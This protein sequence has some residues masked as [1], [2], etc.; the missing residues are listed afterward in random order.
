MGILRAVQH[1]PG[2]GVPAVNV[3]V[4]TSGSV[5][6][7]LADVAGSC[8]ATLEALVRIEEAIP[9]PTTALA[10]ADMVL[11]ARINSMLP[12]GTSK[13]DLARWRDSLGVMFSQLGRPADAL[14]AT[15]EAVT[16]RRE[17]AA[18]NPDRYRPDLARSLSNL[19]VRLSELGRPADAL[20]ATEEAVTIRRELAAANPDRYRPDL[21]RSL[22]NLGVRLSELGRPADAL[23]ATE[24]AVT[25]RRELA[26]ANPDRYR[27]DLAGSLSNL[28]VRLSE[29]GRP[30]DALPATEEAVTIRRELA[31]ANPDRYRRDLAALA[32]QPRRPVLGAGPPGGRPARHRG[33]R[34]DPP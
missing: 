27:R 26:A 30:A 6:P 23:P 10:R 11:T 17:L 4:Q 7:I 18:A 34:H 1:L 28:G 3:A 16:I 14:P 9:Y 22:D 5:G 24:E 20:P 33:S 21:A 2:L 31:A 12:A 29:L 32:V 8:D 15:E 13:A 25:I 19:G